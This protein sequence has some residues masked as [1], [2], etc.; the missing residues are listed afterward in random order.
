M[1]YLQSQMYYLTSAHQRSPGKSC[2]MELELGQ[3]YAGEDLNTSFTE[4]RLRYPKDAILQWL[5]RGQ[6]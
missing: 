3:R 5:R 4:K 1:T 2:V 6:L